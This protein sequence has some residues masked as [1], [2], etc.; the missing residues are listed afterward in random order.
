MNKTE[1]LLIEIRI[2]RNLIEK[3]LENPDLT[4]AEAANLRRMIAALNKKEQELT[5]N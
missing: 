3:D 4:D 2:L 5:Q 1:K